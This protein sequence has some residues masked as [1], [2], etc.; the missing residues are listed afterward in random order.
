MDSR[1]PIFLSASRRDADAARALRDGLIGFQVP[2]S[3]PVHPALQ[4]FVERRVV[5]MHHRENPRRTEVPEEILDAV[6]GSRVMILVCSSHSATSRWIEAELDAFYGA[7]PRGPVIPVVLDGEPEPDLSADAYEKPCFPPN[8]KPADEAR[9]VDAR[10]SDWAET[11]PA[12][13]LSALL[14]VRVEQLLHHVELGRQ[15]FQRQRNWSAYAGGTAVVLALLWSFRFS[16]HHGVEAALPGY[17][18]AFAPA[19]ERWLATTR[20][21]GEG[22]RPVGEGEGVLVAKG[23]EV[24]Q[25]IR[26]V[27]AEPLPMRGDAVPSGAGVPESGDPGSKN[28]GSENAGVASSGP[29]EPP[30]AVMKT[31]SPVIE[32]VPG[33]SVPGAEAVFASDPAAARLTLNAWLDEAERVIPVSLPEGKRWL[34]KT[35]FVLE[36]LPP[37]DFRNEF[38]RFHALAAVVAKRDGRAEVARRELLTAIHHWTALP[39]VDPDAREREAFEILATIA[40]MEDWIESAM[41]VIEWLGELPAA[42]T[43]LLRRADRL[44]ALAEEHPHLV[45]PILSW[46]GSAP[47][48]LA[49]SGAHP[50]ALKARLEL[51]AAFLAE[52]NGLRGSALQALTQARMALEQ[53]GHEDA[54]HDALKAQ[55]RYRLELLRGESEPAGGAAED[56][57]DRLAEGATEPG[58]ETWFDAELLRVW[59]RRGDEAL[60]RDAFDTAVTAY[61]K[62]LEHAQDARSLAQL[63]LRSGCAYRY[64]GDHAGAWDAFSLAIPIFRDAREPEEQLTALY[65][66]LLAAQE[67]GEAEDVQKL[68]SGIETLEQTHGGGYRFPDYWRENTQRLGLDPGVNESDE[69][70]TRELI[71]DRVRELKAR[72]GELESAAVPR[73]TPGTAEELQALH[74]EL[75]SLLQELRERGRSSEV[76]GV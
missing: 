73:L 58:W 25:P 5:V 54:V 11:A 26:P 27:S 48:S 67:L 12:A 46:L 20:D 44:L 28:S 4:R 13:T 22:G 71:E 66:A 69:G 36:S 23:P 10:G 38:Y 53:A 45:S 64:A 62:A 29:D 2:R 21:P 49:G 51:A 50:V 59:S 1:D 70:E 18:T 39:V 42:E 24:P 56:F 6:R 34:G 3:L 47:G 41:E 30:A 33:A 19:V 72:I 74:G 14:N 7:H 31:P 43:E 65:G 35:G 15:A 16:L 60:N 32:P 17:E 61:G 40:P 63:L 9:W 8:L 52:E 55:V 76:P 57:T 37:E 68:R 75:D